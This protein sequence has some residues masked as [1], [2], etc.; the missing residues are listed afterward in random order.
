[1]PPRNVKTISDVIYYYYARLVIARVAGKENEWGFV[2]DRYKKLK[3]GEIHMAN[4]DGEIRVQMRSDNNCVY[5]GG[6]ADSKDHVIPRNYDGP[7]RMQNVVR[8]CKSCNSSKRDH[9]LIDWWI[10]ILGNSEDTLPRIPLGIYLKYSLDWH[11][12][13]DSLDNLANSITDLR[14]FVPGKAR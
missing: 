9:D 2:M 7:D 12:M 6:K 5:C 13:R 14:P 10:N 4:R 11:R 3:S 1:M 8:S